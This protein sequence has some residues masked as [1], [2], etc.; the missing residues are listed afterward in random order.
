MAPLPPQ[1]GRDVVDTVA[2]WSLIVACRSSIVCITCHRGFSRVDSSTRPEDSLPFDIRTAYRPLPRV[3][4]SAPCPPPP[5]PVPP[6]VPPLKA[7]SP[8]SVSRSSASAAASSFSVSMGLL[9]L[10]LPPLPPLLPFPVGTMA[11]AA[12]GV[13]DDEGDDEED[14]EDSMV[15]GA[16]TL[17]R[18][19]RDTSGKT[20]RDM[21][22]KASLWPFPDYWA[23]GGAAVGGGSSIDVRAGDE[24]RDTAR[25][26]GVD[27]RSKDRRSKDR[28]V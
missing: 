25:R 13:E 10:P 28:R 17:A 3:P 16:W 15:S 7:T 21:T 6:P 5:P 4:P 23:G 19:G 22:P 12:V 27:R 9:P 8:T 18:R 14:E 26:G 2:T 11:P 24:H 1:P 20:T